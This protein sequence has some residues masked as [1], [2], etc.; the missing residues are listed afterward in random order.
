MKSI[1]CNDIDLFMIQWISG[2]ITI[3]LSHSYFYPQ[4][5]IEK[6]TTGL[7]FFEYIL[8]INV[9]FLKIFTYHVHL[10]LISYAKLLYKSNHSCASAI[11][12]YIM[13]LNSYFLLS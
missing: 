4:R 13:K 12:A 9:I 6:I 5:N 7:A 10:I 3:Y 11:T 2:L 8:C 1:F